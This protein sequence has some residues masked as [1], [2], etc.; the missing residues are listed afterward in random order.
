MVML[1][2]P[3]EG[4]TE[5]TAVMPQSPAGALLAVLDSLV[6]SLHKLWMCQMSCSLFFPHLQQLRKISRV[7]GVNA[8]LQ[9]QWFIILSR[10]LPLV[11][12]VSVGYVKSVFLESETTLMQCLSR[13]HTPGSDVAVAAFLFSVQKVPEDVSMGFPHLPA[14]GKN[15]KWL[16]LCLCMIKESFAE[17]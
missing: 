15:M 14:T 11:F 6:P 13:L 10:T 9:Q 12:K 5:S 1:A 8:G 2:H 16:F 17:M 4:C 7:A 3:E